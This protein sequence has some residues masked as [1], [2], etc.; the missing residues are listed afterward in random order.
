MSGRTRRERADHGPVRSR[1][2]VPDKSAT[3][4]DRSTLILLIGGAL[5][6]ASGISFLLG[7]ATG[8]SIP[9]LFGGPAGRSFSP[10]GLGFPNFAAPSRVVGDGG[11]I[12]GTVKSINSNSIV[13]QLADGSTVTIDMTGNPSYHYEA[14][15]SGS[16]ASGPP[17][18]GATVVVQL[19]A[20]ASP[21]PNVDTNSAVTVL[22]ALDVIVTNH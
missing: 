14:G 22:R 18:V 16:P 15:P 20:N 2:K 8:G 17:A 9:G 19:D 11:A 6:A 13:L 5:V 7:T 21:D 10:N 4:M 3:R 1:R 12:S